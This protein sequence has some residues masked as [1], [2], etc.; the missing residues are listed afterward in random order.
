MRR[1]AFDDLVAITDA[2]FQADLARLRA[3]AA[4][5]AELR[6]ELEE[7]ARA[8][9]RNAAADPDSIAALNRIGGDILW[10]AW[11]G[12]KRETLNLKLA[13]VLARRLVAAQ[14][15]RRS[16]G[17]IGFET[18]VVGDF[19]HGVAADG[20]GYP[21]RR[22]VHRIRQRLGQRDRATELAVV[23]FRRPGA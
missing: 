18:E 12:R 6:A 23:V 9:R 8:E 7:L 3:I 16:F 21:D 1:D 4:E 10:K 5:E 22:R 19:A 15:L 13:T 11:I 20:F 17:K 14:T 2:V